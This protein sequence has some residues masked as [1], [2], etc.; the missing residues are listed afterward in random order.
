[1]D[2]YFSVNWNCVKCGRC[3]TACKNEGNNYLTGHRDVSP[4]EYNYG[5]DYVPCHHCEGDF[6]HKPCQLVC[7]YD[8]IEIERC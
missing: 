2:T 1:M 6:H 5:L 4:N 7:H 8:A 3:V